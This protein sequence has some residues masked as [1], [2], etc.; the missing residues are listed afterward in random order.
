MRARHSL[1][2][3]LAATLSV[4]TL[5]A[6]GSTGEDGPSEAADAGYPVSIDRCDRTITVENRPERIVSLNQASTEILL[7][8][9]VADRMVGTASWTDPIL[10]SLADENA[11]VERL[12]DQA[13]SYEAVLAT[14]PDLIT[15]SLYNTLSEGGVATAEQFADLGVPAY[16]SA[17]EC[18]KSDFGGGDGARD[19]PIT[20]ESIYTEITD[21]ATLVDEQQ[22]GQ[23]LIDDLADRMDA[24]VSAAPDVD[25]V[26]VLYWFANSESPYVGGCCGGPGIATHA[27]GL[28]NVFEGQNAEWPQIGWEAIADADPDV[29]VIGD[30][31][32]KSQTA[33]TAAAKIEYLESN[34]VT[35]E[36]T[37]VKEKQYVTVAGAELNPS[38]RTV[39]LVEQMSAGLVELGLAK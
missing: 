38:I 17:V 29:L 7:S 21:L 12:A 11:K 25:G 36:M 14:E 28:T 19:E 31:T 3:F 26:T 34:P 35:K 4:A 6:C 30:L 15:A 32:R 39:D 37:A 18:E 13:P 10:D 2:S 9:G 20:M 27:L 8:L 24:A 1:L 16:L 22:A 33:E 5:V 23:D